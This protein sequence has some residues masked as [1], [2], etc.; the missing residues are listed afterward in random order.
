MQDDIQGLLAYCSQSIRIE[1]GRGKK[2]QAYVVALPKRALYE[3]KDCCLL[4][5]I[6]SCHKKPIISL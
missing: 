2:V 3:A 6:K 1:R 5:V 4:H